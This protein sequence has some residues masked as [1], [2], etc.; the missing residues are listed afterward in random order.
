MPRFAANISMMFR[1]LPFLDRFEAASE[2][3][4]K[5]VEALFPYDDAA[6]EITTRLSR[7]DL[8]MV[9]I[10]CPPP[11]WAGGERGFAAVPSLSE[12]FR[13]DFKRAAR[14]AQALGAQHMHIMA[15]KSK[16][17]VARSCFVDNL[18]WACDTAPKMSLTIEP[19][20]AQD[21]PG[22]FLNDFDQA[23]EILDEV[24]APNLGLQ[25]DMYHAQMITHD[26]MKTWE[27]HGHRAVHIQ[28]AGA[29]G[30]HE[31]H[32][33]ECD[34][35]KFFRLL[36]ETSY[37]GW[38]SGEYNPRTSTEQGLTWFYDTEHS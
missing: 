5:G 25:F 10:N 36:D 4:F 19:I 21:M 8:T 16:G 22:Y 34:Y 29:P 33:C 31:P 1:E 18:K 35:P 23:A 38:V 27:T 2:A 32:G 17:V 28:I 15:G 26:G 9:L 30:R 3:G 37:G 11:N 13:R 14:Y 7:H 6:G 12:R 20:N 24:D